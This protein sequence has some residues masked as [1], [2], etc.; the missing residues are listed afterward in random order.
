[1]HAQRQHDYRVHEAQ[2]AYDP[3]KHFMHFMI[4]PDFFFPTQPNQAL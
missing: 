3:T 4:Y 2:N 1:M